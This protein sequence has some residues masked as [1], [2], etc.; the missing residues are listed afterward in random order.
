MAQVIVESKAIQ[1][2]I[3]QPRVQ[4]S[5]GL[6]GGRLVRAVNGL[7]TLTS[8]DTQNTTYAAGASVYRVGKVRSSDYYHQLRV[9]TTADMGTT[10]TVDIGLYRV[11][12]SATAPGAVVDQDFFASTLSL[13][14]N[15]IVTTGSGV[16]AADQTFEAAAAGGLITNAE[17]Q[18]WEALGLSV[19]PGLEY[20]VAL[21]LTGAC[22]G[23]GTALVQV[24]VVR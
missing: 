24:I 10:T 18:I 5:T 7:V 19:D 4:N 6:E 20:E 21:T 2:A 13:K 9:V 12:D 1:N 14:D 23:T 17:K 22:D 8:G 11:S 3:A 16:N 15:A